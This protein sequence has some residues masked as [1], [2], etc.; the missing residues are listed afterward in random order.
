[1]RKSAFLIAAL[2]LVSATTVAFA[3]KKAAAPA[4]PAK[5]STTPA[6]ANESSMRIVRDGLSQVFVPAQSLAK[7]PAVAAKP[8]AAPAKPKKAKKKA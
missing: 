4:A 3:Q 2:M 7:P 1:M 6:N 5:Y 8:A